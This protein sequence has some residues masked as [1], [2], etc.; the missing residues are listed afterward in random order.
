MIG[1]I[2]RRKGMIDRALQHFTKA[3][4]LDPKDTNMVKSLIDKIHSSGGPGSMG[5]GL[6]NDLNDDD[7]DIQIL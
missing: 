5:T 6:G 7:G 2:Y 1:K 3:L 4:D